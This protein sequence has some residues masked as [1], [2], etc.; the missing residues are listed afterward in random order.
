MMK[1]IELRKRNNH[2]KLSNGIVQVTGKYY[3]VHPEEIEH[4][5]QRTISVVQETHPDEKILKLSRNRGDLIIELTSAKLA[6][7]VGRALNNAYGGKTLYEM[8]H[9]TG[10]GRVYWERNELSKAMLE[11]KEKGRKRR[12]KR[13][14]KVRK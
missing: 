14:A 8:M 13:G 1:K 6:Q 9:D 10:Q 5:I 7:R 11:S 3:E 12:R 4:L 2:K